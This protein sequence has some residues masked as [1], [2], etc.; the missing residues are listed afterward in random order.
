[1]VFIQLIENGIFR[2]VNDT[3]FVLFKFVHNIDKGVA[4]CLDNFKP[5]LEAAKPNELKNDAAV[6]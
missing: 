6:Y 2:L 4:K 3:I 1:M 5:V